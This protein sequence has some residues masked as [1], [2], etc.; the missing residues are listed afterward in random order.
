MHFSRAERR[1][2]HKAAMARWHKQPDH[3]STSSI[4]KSKTDFKDQSKQDDIFHNV[5]RVAFATLC[6]GSTYHTIKEFLNLMDVS[7]ISKTSFYDAS[8]TVKNAVESLLHE[9]LVHFQTEIINERVEN[10]VQFTACFDGAF[11]HAR[12][13][14]ECVVDIIHPEKKKSFAVC[15]IEKR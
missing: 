8:E 10:G 3:P 2:V 1:S 5:L 15:I 4:E 7:T 9:K 13:A 14:P 6:T 11:S 12:N